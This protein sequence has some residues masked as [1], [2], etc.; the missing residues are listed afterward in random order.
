MFHG[1]QGMSPDW[2]ELIKYTVM[3]YGMIAM[4]V[5]V[6]FGKSDDNKTF[7]GNTVKGHIV[8]GLTEITKPLCYKNIYLDVYLLIEFVA[9]IE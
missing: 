8:R 2:S 7:K 5:R 6:Q 3:G 4:D 9:M 1:Y